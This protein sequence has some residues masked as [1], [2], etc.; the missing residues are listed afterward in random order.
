ML[1]YQAEM[2]KIELIEQLKG[3][4]KNREEIEMAKFVEILK[5]KIEK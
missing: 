3:Y 1:I 5:K 2:D 4:F